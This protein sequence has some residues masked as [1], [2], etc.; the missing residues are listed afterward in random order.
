MNKFAIVD[1]KGGLGNQLFTI[2][3]AEHL[4]Q[5][6]YKVYAD[7]SFYKSS[8][9]HPRELLID[10]EHFGFKEINL[11]S[12]RIFKFFNTSF[13]E[14]EDLRQIYTKKINRFNGYY[15]NTS[16]L[17]KSYL[18]KKLSIDNNQ[19]Q[20]AVMMHL[21]KGDYIKLNEELKL[22]YYKEAVNKIEKKLNNFEINIFSDDH[23]LKIS[24]FKNFNVT[25]IFNDKNSDDLE[26]FKEMTQF[27]NFV[28]ANSTFSFLAAFLGENN[29]STIY[30]PKPWMR[31]SDVE[32]K[33]V[34][35]NW[36]QLLNN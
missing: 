23:T 16:F 26:I 32:I 36:I 9:D 10:I 18:I 12:D 33:K 35:T 22:S 20:G 14:I 31:N 28:I 4:N 21:R 5:N 11:K 13:E 19:K 34:P 1:I 17:D 8:H 27:Q 24:D 29:S 30:Y 7:T 3:F 25:R 2:S 6:G 15:Q